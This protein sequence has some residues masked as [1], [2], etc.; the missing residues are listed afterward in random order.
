MYNKKI[1]DLT[2]YYYTLDLFSNADE[3]N[4]LDTDIAK[5][6]KSGAGQDVTESL[7]EVLATKDSTTVAANMN[8]LENLF[9]VGE[10]DFRK[11][12]RCQV[13]NILLL[14]ASIILIV[15]IA[16]KCWCICFLPLVCLLMIL[17]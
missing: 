16:A 1:F 6:I 12:A 10:N 17:F 8:C 4:Y 5:A 15:T 13:Q 3:Y 9:Y 11:T 2:D 14:V 7:N